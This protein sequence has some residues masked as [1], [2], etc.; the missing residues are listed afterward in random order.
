[1]VS[2]QKEH[3]GKDQ[4]DAR[5]KQNLRSLFHDILPDIADHIRVGMVETRINRTNFPVSVANTLR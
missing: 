4:A 3:S 1:M 5:H 2:N